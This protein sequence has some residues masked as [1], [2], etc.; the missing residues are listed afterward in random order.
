MKVFTKFVIAYYFYHIIMI[1]VF[2]ISLILLVAG[3]DRAESNA[4]INTILRIPEMTRFLDAFR[5]NGTKE[6]ALKS[7]SGVDKIMTSFI[8]TL[9]L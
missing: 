9:S 4:F 6:M 1:K 5:E 2:I 7:L 3:A 8:R